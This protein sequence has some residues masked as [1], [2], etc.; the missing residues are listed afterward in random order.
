MIEVLSKWAKNITLAV[1]I[2]SIVEMLLPNNKTKK[3]IKVVMGIYILWN[4]ISPIVGKDIT[5]D[6]DNIINGTDSKT[7]T[8]AM[9]NVNQTSMDDRLKEICE[10]ELEKDITNTITENGYIVNSCRVDIDTTMKNGIQEIKNI[11]KI[12]LN[13]EKTKE[14][15]ENAQPKDKAKS[16]ENA[17]SK[18][19]VENEDDTQ[20]EENAQSKE[21]EEDSKQE[22]NEISIE[23]IMVKEV[24]KI[25]NV[26]IGYESKK[27]GKKQ[28]KESESKLSIS[29][30]NSIKKIL[31]DKYGVSD[32]CLKIN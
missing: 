23:N 32:K 28:T 14:K 11:N 13:I 30:I 5:F 4:I 17:Q 8:V 10:E 31:C 15:E 1:V 18:D 24:Q 6:L 19:K 20:F 2:V 7:T 29:D 21:Q 16:R 3:Y 27:E 22:E 25:K 26:K 12:A 9:Q